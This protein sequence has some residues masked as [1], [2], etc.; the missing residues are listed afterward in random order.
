MP[1]KLSHPLVVFAGC[2][3]LDCNKEAN[4]R[5]KKIATISNS[6]YYVVIISYYDLIILIIL[7]ITSILQFTLFITF[8]TASVLII[9]AVVRVL[10]IGM[11]A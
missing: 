8:S 7:R 1:G 5:I 3:C 10:L 6:Y 9:A 11:D 4:R 2:K